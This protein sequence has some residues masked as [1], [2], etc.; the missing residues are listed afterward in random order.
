MVKL[1]NRK[2]DRKEV[3][4]YQTEEEVLYALDTIIE[5]CNLIIA[6]VSGLS[7]ED[8]LTDD[9][10]MKA[11]A[12]DMLVIGNYA[13]RFPSEILDMSSNLR[14]AYGFRCRVA[15]DYGTIRFESEYLWVAVSKDVKDILKTCLKAKRMISEGRMRFDR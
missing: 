12:I 6:R 10:K 5:C 14:N 4:T 1:F 3:K 7:K 13:G 9:D 2:K 8:F 11:S 15:H